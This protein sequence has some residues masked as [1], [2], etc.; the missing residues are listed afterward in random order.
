MIVLAGSAS[1]YLAD[2]KMKS[3]SFIF[4]Q[5]LIIA[6]GMSAMLAVVFFEV[7][8]HPNTPLTE[9]TTVKFR[10]TSDTNQLRY[11]KCPHS[12][13]VTVHDVLY[14]LAI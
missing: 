3:K 10:V 11:W 2:P 7:S 12:T 4:L 6:T 13:S 8:F 1:G 14:F 9:E 5:N